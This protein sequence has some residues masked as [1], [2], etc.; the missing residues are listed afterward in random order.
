MPQ[1]NKLTKYREKPDFTRTAFLETRQCVC[2]LLNH[3][4]PTSERTSLAAA[5]GQ[6]RLEGG[7]C[8]CLATM[9]PYLAH[10]DWGVISQLGVH[11]VGQNSL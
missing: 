4:Q 7:V 3:R 10:R 11:L 5:S 6:P 2:Q 1:Q 9:T 8:N